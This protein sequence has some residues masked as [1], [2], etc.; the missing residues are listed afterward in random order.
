M[1][2]SGSTAVRLRA[3]CNCLS[4]CLAVSGVPL[5]YI[6]PISY[7]DV[8]CYPHC[9]SELVNNRVV[10]LACPDFSPDI[11]ACTPCI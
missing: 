6:H 10:L 4:L 5:L 1:R 9:I 7:D 11:D 3:A 8:R 2:G